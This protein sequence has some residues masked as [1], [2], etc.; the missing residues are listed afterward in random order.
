MK[1]LQFRPV[2][3]P[4]RRQSIAWSLARLLAG[5]HFFLTATVATSLAGPNETSQVTG[6]R[7]MLDIPPSPGNPRNSEGAFLELKDGRILFIYSRFEGK[8]SSDHAKARLA[9]RYSSD[10]GETWSDDTI[11]TTPEEDQVMNVMDVSLLRMGNGD[12]G[13]FYNLRRSWRDMR[14]QLRRSSDEG[15]TWSEPMQCIPV[16]GYWVVLND[17]IVRLSSGRLVLPAV[18]HRQRMDFTP[19]EPDA[20]GSEKID[21]RGVA[22][23]F[24]SDDDGRTWREAPG[25]GTIPVP[26]T[27][28]GLQE[29]GVVE[30][31][32]GVLWAWNRT[33]LGRQYEFFSGDGGETW[34]QPGPSR[35][36]SPRSPMS[37]KRIPNTD[38]FLAIWNPAPN[39]ETRPIKPI[40]GDRTPLVGAIGPG[41]F[42]AWTPA[43]VIEGQDDVDAGYHYTAIHFTKDAV[44]LA[45]CAGNAQDKGGLNRVR[46][47]KM[48]LS[49]FK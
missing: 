19:A 21:R 40:G 5:F 23:F 28:S 37:I 13:M 30:L 22:F 32:N 45:Y 14:L 39:Y 27:K 29:T 42:G 1:T 9:K 47:R 46:I 33:D 35:F 36:T 6:S 43:Y 10:G 16:A 24:L 31:L 44:L 49:L 26:H 3:R 11:L 20:W 25:F 48:S 17:R 15:L 8:S 4:L 41:P 12:I 34:S 38:R 18:L 7:L 2:R